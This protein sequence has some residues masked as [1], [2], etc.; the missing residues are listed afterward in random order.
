MGVRGFPLKCGGVNGWGRYP[1]REIERERGVE[2]GEEGER[3]MKRGTERGGDTP[4]QIWEGRHDHERKREMHNE[5]YNERERYR[6]RETNKA[7]VRDTHT[8]TGDHS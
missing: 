6:D 3:E 5:R 2:R 7:R 8:I 1:A 4:T